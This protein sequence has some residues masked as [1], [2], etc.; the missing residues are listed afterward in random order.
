MTLQ[1]N[2]NEAEKDLLDPEYITI[3]PDKVRISQATQICLP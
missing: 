1:K 2:L 3:K